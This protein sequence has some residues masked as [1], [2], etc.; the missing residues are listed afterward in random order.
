MQ[1]ISDAFQVAY[2]YRNLQPLGDTDNTLFR[3]LRARKMDVTA[4]A[5]ML[6]SE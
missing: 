6:A 4:A 2:N 3:F 1:D 5:D